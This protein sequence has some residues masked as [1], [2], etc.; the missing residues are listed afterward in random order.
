MADFIV[1]DFKG[2]VRKRDALRI[3]SLKK[4]IAL[5]LIV[6]LI[7]LKLKNRQFKTGVFSVLHLRTACSRRPV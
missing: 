2:S 4:K 3:F 5:Q 1:L 7:K 6:D